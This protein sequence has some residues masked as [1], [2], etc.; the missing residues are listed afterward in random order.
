MFWTSL[1]HGRLDR[2]AANWLF[3]AADRLLARE[4]EAH[5]FARQ[6]SGIFTPLASRSRRN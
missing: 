6:Q 4:S 1:F 2:G 3:I 5:S